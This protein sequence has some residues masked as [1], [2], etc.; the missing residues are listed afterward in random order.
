METKKI[1]FK[2]VGHL[3]T[4]IYNK[5][6]FLKISDN[7]AYI[8]DRTNSHHWKKISFNPEQ[9]VLLVKE[10]KMKK[11]ELKQ[12]IKEELKK[13]FEEKFK[14]KPIK[15]LKPG[16]KFFIRNPKSIYTFIKLTNDTTADVLL[17]NGRQSNVSFGTKMA[18][19]I[20]KEDG[21]AQY[22]RQGGR[23]WD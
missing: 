18:N 17:P 6:R 8:N 13:L 5:T 21:Y 2:D 4:F 20:G 12:I 11:S 22:L 1:K 3:D 9:T 23:D 14:P 7:N 19:E 16:E 15:T 10:T